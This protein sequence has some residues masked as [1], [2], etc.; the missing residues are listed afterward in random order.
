MPKD[1]DTVK[2]MKGTTEAIQLF[3]NIPIANFKKNDKYAFSINS[4]DFIERKMIILHLLYRIQ[5]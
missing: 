4:N 3:K 1:D 2:V 5:F